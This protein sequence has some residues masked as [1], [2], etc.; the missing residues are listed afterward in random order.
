MKNTAIKTAG[1]DSFESS[2][3]IGELTQE[4]QDVA[5]QLRD[6]TFL[7]RAKLTINEEARYNEIQKKYRACLLK[8]K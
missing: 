7:L 3:R 4:I 8:E 1:A 6:I 2:L 5:C